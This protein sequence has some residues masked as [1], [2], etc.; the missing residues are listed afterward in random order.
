[1]ILTRRIEI[2]TNKLRGSDVICY[3][4]TIKFYQIETEIFYISLLVQSLLI[5]HKLSN[6]YPKKNL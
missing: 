3:N 6:L 5:L 4:I 1:M 2:V